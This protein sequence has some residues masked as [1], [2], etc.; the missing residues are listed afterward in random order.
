M[1]LFYDNNKIEIPNIGADYKIGKVAFF[2]VVKSTLR[3]IIEWMFLLLQQIF[4]CMSYCEHVIKLITLN[5]ILDHKTK[6][7]K[8]K[9]TLV[10]S[11]ILLLSLPILT[12]ASTHFL[13]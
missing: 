7:I 10:D 5:S 1:N 4:S 6:K 2:N 3:I 12:V 11:L 9:I 13:Q 8:I